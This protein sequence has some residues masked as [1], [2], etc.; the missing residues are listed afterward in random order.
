LQ[1]TPFFVYKYE[2]LLKNKKKHDSNE[3]NLDGSSDL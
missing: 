3:N 1:E 2:I